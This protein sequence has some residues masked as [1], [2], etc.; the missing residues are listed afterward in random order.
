[1]RIS[2]RWGRSSRLKRFLSMPKKLGASRRRIKRGC[3]RQVDGGGSRVSACPVL[4]AR[5]PRSTGAD[6]GGSTDSMLSHLRM[7]ALSK[8]FVSSEASFHRCHIVPEAPRCVCLGF[9][10]VCAKTCGAPMTI[11]HL[12]V[13]LS[14][15]WLRVQVSGE[16]RQKLRRRQRGLAFLRT[17]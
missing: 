17:P 12:A 1:M 15:S 4:A 3:G 16:I 9:E 10:R 7:D 14:L 11:S 13:G 2:V 6:E 8:G 5:R